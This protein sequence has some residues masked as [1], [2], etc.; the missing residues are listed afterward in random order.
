MTELKIGYHTGTLT[1]SKL[2]LTDFK[3]ELEMMENK[4]ITKNNATPM[5][6]PK[7]AHCF[8]PAILYIL[9]HIR[10]PLRTKGLE[11]SKRVPAHI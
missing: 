4:Q 5:A 10:E 8:D 9:I 7:Q 3:N 6:G 2:T 11:F 1:L